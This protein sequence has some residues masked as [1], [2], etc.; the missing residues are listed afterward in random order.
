MKR[1]IK[2][3]WEIAICICIGFIIGAIILGQTFMTCGFGVFCIIWFA[4]CLHYQ[5]NKDPLIS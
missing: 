4:I 5:F 1:T 2:Q 3:I